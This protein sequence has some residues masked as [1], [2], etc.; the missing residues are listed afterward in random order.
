MNPLDF[1]LFLFG[2]FAARL[3]KYWSA[4]DFTSTDTTPAR[5]NLPKV[6]ASLFIVFLF[7][8]LFSFV[9]MSQYY[10]TT[11]KALMAGLFYILASYTADSTFQWLVELY[12]NWKKAKTLAG[13][14][15]SSQAEIKQIDA[16]AIQ[17]KKDITENNKQ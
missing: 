1:H 3:I 11:N 2:G 17:D 10:A 13:L 6:A 15:L 8:L 16:T 5:M 9:D 14:P 7:Y 4:G 12:N